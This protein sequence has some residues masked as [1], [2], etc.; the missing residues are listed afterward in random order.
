MAS[1]GGLFSCPQ[2]PVHMPKTFTLLLTCTIFFFLSGFCQ[3]RPV[4]ILKGIVINDS[5]REP[6]PYATVTIKGRSIS[7]VTNEEGRFIVKFYANDLKKDSLVIAC[8]G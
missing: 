3:Q 7:T 6:V 1:G 4:T 5:T 8:V 2:P